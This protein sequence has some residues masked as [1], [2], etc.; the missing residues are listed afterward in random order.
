MRPG[1]L[2]PITAWSLRSQ[3]A[4]GAACAAVAGT[5]ILSVAIA[6]LTLSRLR[7]DA[8]AAVQA[9]ALQMGEVLSR[10]M[11]E[12]FNDIYV[13]S[14]LGVMADPQVP[15]SEKR[16]LL[17]NL[18]A[19]FPAYAWI[20]VT[21]NAGTVLAATG[22]LLEGVDVSQRP[23]FIDGRF[24]TTVK[25]VHEAKLLAKLLPPEPGGAPL[26]LVD[27]AAPLR[28]ASGKRVGVIGAHLSWRWATEVRDALLRTRSAG[29]GLEIMVADQ[30]GNVILGPTNLVGH[31]LDLDS[32][33]DGR[34]GAHGYKVETW[35]DGQRYLTG[36]AISPGHG[37]YPG[38]GWLVLVRQP[39]AVA[40]AA[41]DKLQAHI[42]IGGALISLALAV[43]GWFAA[44]H[45][46]RPLLTIAAGA[47]RLADDEGR[48]PDA[49]E[50]I[51]E[52]GGSREVNMLGRSLRGLLG[53]L[54]ARE[55]SLR[56]LNLSLEG[57]VAERTQSLSAAN[58]ELTREIELREG[59]EREREAL[60][61]KL[62]NLAET[63]ALTGLLN[64]RAFLEQGERE[65]R[66]A[67]RQQSAIAVV[68]LDLDHFKK[69]NDQHGHPTGDA[70]LRATA[71]TLGAHLRE[72]DILGRLG[73]EEFAAVLTNCD[74]AG[75]AELAER[76]RAAIAAMTVPLETGSAGAG[77]GDGG[78][79]RVTASLGYALGDGAG[80]I[81]LEGLIKAADAALYRAKAEGRN[82]V[83]AAAADVQ[84]LLRGASGSSRTRPS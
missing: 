70:V 42:I 59:L 49:G 75:A 30:V 61:S 34:T 22:G 73:G 74:P 36:F 13:L 16:R 48:S 14:S 18:Q 46:T 28:D 65:L 56:E 43:I 2:K 58:A 9:T 76:L 54:S 23:W 44:R 38:L 5:L 15:A 24:G 68:M 25:D 21:D 84:P 47:E 35:P 11:F 39:V 33:A 53:K 52:I 10:G 29:A 64:R 55:R 79:L 26:R 1:W 3:L 8:G 67:R 60:I 50:T 17:E 80:D 57:R 72:F 82:R 62:R 4:F 37:P 71:A 81:H 78:T 27:F 40:F 12:R 41:A 32:V 19:S 66:R 51:P 83:C 31:R 20:G 6:S 77:P 69:V 7:D 45:V 63:D